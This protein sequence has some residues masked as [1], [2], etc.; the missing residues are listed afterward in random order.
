MISTGVPD[1][2][3]TLFPAYS[4]IEDFWKNWVAR[5]P[6]REPLPSLNLD[7]GIQ[8]MAAVGFLGS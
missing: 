5:E 8:G 7:S 2:L 4:L 6:S 3:E 1:P